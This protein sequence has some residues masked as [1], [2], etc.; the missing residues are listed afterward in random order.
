[1]SAY[2]AEI[3]ELMSR[4]RQKLADLIGLQRRVV[5]SSA[6]VASV[7]QSV[8]VTV[9]GQGEITALEFP[10]GAFRVMPAAELSEEILTAVRDAKAKA[11]EPLKE[12]LA[13]DLLDGSR[14]LELIQNQVDAADPRPAGPS[15]RSEDG[16]AG[17]R[18]FEFLDI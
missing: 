7:Y 10:T 1:M 18:G 17:G 12:L 8:R 16:C 3:A 4:Y 6:T 14:L 9:N 11:R 2:E 13:L 15:G 5:E